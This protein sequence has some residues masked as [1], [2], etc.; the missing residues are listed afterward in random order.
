MDPLTHVFLPLTVAYVLASELFPTP[1]YLLLGLFGLVPDLDKLLGVPG[2]LHS[3]LT[4]VPLCVALVVADRRWGGDA[5]YGLLAVAFVTVHLFLD[6]LDGSGLYALYPL[7][8]TGV[9]L[10]YPLSVTFGEGLLGFQF[11]GWPVVL[12]VEPAPTGFAESAAVD[13]N[14]FGFLAPYGLASVL[15]FCCIYVG[16]LYRDRS[17]AWRAEA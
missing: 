11:E 8:E 1:R 12:D 6:F 17:I 15:T 10:A 9:G 7:V 2:L 5:P 4:V 16:E 3:L 14:T 13:E